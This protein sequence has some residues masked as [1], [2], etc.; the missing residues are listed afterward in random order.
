MKQTVLQEFHSLS[1]EQT[2][3]FAAGI[4]DKLKSGETVLLFGTLGSGKTFLVKAL[5]RLLGSN[6]E[7][8]SPSFAILNQYE[9][10]VSVNHLD[11]YRI[12]DKRE[13]INLGL[14]DLWDS[15]AINFV[16]WPQL[17]ED[18]IQWPHYR[19]YIEIDNTNNKGRIFKLIRYNG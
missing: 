9:G 1:Q 18:Q 13:L 10:P 19:I 8:T 2:E 17:I 3:Q 12:A 4:L 14:E 6:A 7:A 16:E 5:V 15:A 11:L